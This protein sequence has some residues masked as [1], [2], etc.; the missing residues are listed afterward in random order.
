MRS[1]ASLL[2]PKFTPTMPSIGRRAKFARP[3]SKPSLLNPR[4]LISP[5]SAR[6]AKHPRL[7]I[8]GLRP[9]RQRADFDETKSER[10]QSTGNLGVLVEAGGEPERRGKPQ[11][12]C[13]DGKPRIARGRRT[14]RR[15]FQR[16]DRRPVG[17][18]RRKARERGAGERA[19]RSARIMPSN[20]RNDGVRRS[21]M[22]KGA[23]PDNRRHRQRSIEMREQ[24]AAARRLPF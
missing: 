11:T 17:G 2:G 21:P 20:R 24:L 18:F 10:E 6:Q 22:R 9:R 16:R 3:S 15:Q 4:R 13:V 1:A 12:K 14:E 8:A 7:G 19:G 5:A 23:R